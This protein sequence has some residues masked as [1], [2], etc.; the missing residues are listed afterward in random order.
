MILG[1]ENKYAKQLQVALTSGSE[2]EQQQAWNDFSNSIVESIKADAEIYA[3]TGD[4]NILAQRGYRQLTSAEERFYDKFIE[5]SKMRNVQMAVTTLKDLKD[6]LVILEK[7]LKSYKVDE[8]F[9][10]NGLQKINVNTLKNM[11]S[12]RSSIINMMKEQS[13]IRLDNNLEL[14]D[15]YKDLIKQQ[16][17]YY[18]YEE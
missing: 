16:N 14:I 10:E 15:S 2:E 13:K 12:T 8:L 17:D 11:A 1:N 18:N 6:N 7:W 5:A 4:K 3:Q 9:D